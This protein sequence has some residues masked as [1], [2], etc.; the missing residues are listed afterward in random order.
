LSRVEVVLTDIEGTIA[1]I[2]FVQKV[3]F[4][5]ARQAL[6][7]FVAAQADDPDVARE[8]QAVADEAGLDL[9]DIDGLVAQLLA[10]IDA[11]R[12]VTA[13]K[14]LQG[15]V[16]RHGY[17]QGEFRG[18]LYP[19]AHQALEHWHQAGVPLYVY[20]SGSIQAQ[21]LYFAHTEFGDISSWFD[22]FFDTTSGPKREVASYHRIAAVIGRDPAGI[23]FLSDIGD[24]LDAARAAGLQTLQVCRSGTVPAESHRQVRDLSE[25]VVELA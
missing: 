4:P 9:A 17:E 13:L 21:L 15:M 24:E 16:W 12:K 25:P 8:L 3:L 20:S 1:D 22:G 19:D 14:A 11:D 5:Y 10:W 18:H 6:P 23:L 2:A 7:G